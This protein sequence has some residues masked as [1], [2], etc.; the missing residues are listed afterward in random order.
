MRSKNGYTVIELVVL[1]AILGVVTLVFLTKTSYIFKKE[2]SAKINDDAVI[3]NQAEKYAESIK[4]ELKEENTKVILVQ[5]LIDNNYLVADE[6][7]KYVS[8]EDETKYLN[9][10]KIEISYNA[11]EDKI[12]VVYPK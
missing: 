6:N 11:E 1:I 10:E 5:T 4:E 12:N 8:R 9:D 2:Q 7:G 3:E